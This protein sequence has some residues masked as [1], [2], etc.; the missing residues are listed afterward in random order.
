MWEAVA[1]FLDV[2]KLSGWQSGMIAA[3]AG[4]FL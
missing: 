3:A 4:L 1:K 2:F